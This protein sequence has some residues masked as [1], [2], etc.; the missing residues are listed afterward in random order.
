[1]MPPAPQVVLFG[2]MQGDWREQT[3]IPVLE[4]LGVRY[5]NPHEPG[6]NWNPDKGSVEAEMMAA[7]ETI[8]IVI[9][10]KTAAFTSLMETGW[11]ALGA[12]Q[13]GQTLILAVLPE[14]YVEILPFYL[15]IFPKVREMNYFLNHY[16][17]SMRNLVRG[18]AQQFDLP[19]LIVTDSLD[20]VV[21]ALKDR[22]GRRLDE[23]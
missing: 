21:A 8:V 13:R 5:Y 23:R 2:S 15:R 16:A 4:A 20:G 22:Y 3:V 9:N 12:T 6:I 18:H 19:G 7:C 1:M 17:K 10:G 14:E 11:A